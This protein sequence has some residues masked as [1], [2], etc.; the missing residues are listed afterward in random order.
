M[1]RQRTGIVIDNA[2]R[3]AAGGIS[4]FLRLESAG[5]LLL[6]ATEVLA[7]VCS[8]S[9][10]RHAYDDLLKIPVEVRFGSLA[11]AKPLLY[12]ASS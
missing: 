10:L 2:I 1:R 11:V 9:P 7:L 4:D 8:N 3:E 6:M 12:S 5:R